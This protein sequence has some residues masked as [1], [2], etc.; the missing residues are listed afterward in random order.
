MVSLGLS[1]KKQGVLE[2]SLV[3]IRG[4]AMKSFDAT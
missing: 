1:H 2:I 4:V 3:I